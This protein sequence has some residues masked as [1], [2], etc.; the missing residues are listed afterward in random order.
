MLASLIFVLATPVTSTVETRAP[1]SDS[2]VV[3]SSIGLYPLTTLIIQAIAAVLMCAALVVIVRGGLPAGRRLLLIGA[4]VGLFPA[5]VP[6]V[7][8]FTA[9]LT[10]GRTP[11]AR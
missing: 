7:L 6:G 11:P 9:W 10:F 1:G 8:G 4:I 3:E 2:I 5:V